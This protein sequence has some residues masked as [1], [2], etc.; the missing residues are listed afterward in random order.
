MKALIKIIC[1]LLIVGGVA[2]GAHA[3]ATKADK[4]A[5][6]IAEIVMLINT[7]NFVFMATYANP[8]RGMQSRALTT[9]YDL[10][11]SG[12]TLTAYLPYFGRAYLADYNSATE[13][14]IKFTTTEFDYKVT[15]GKKGNF[16]IMITPLKSSLSDP[17]A[18][19][20]MRLDVTPDGYASLQVISLNRD[21]ISFE[22]EIRKK[23]KPKA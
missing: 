16:S 1:A 23:E 9:E 14:G 15:K 8:T 4:K 5:A 20:T 17:R 6:R 19:K 11:L 2:Q 13:G 12:D 3:Q 7:K 21:P 22:G 18:V 10:T